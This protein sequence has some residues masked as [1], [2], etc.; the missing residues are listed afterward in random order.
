MFDLDH[1]DIDTINSI[2]DFLTNEIIGAKFDY[3][4]ASGYILFISKNGESFKKASSTSIEYEC[5]LN[6]GSYKQS[7]ERNGTPKCKSHFKEQTQ[8][9]VV[10]MDSGHVKSPNVSR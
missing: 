5:F 8:G 1:T 6:S 3:K 4:C 10:K 9:H 7:I 2:Y